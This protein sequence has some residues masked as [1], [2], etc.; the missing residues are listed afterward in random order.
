MVAPKDA[1]D[2]PVAPAKPSDAPTLTLKYT[3]K[4][5]PKKP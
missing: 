4:E 5:L 2:K 3:I 1:K